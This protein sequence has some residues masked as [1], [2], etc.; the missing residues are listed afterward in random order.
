MLTK[1]PPHSADAERGVLGSILIDKDGIIQVSGL[2]SPTDFY[3]NAHTLVYDAMLDLFAVNRP[4]DL[5]TVRELL[6]DR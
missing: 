1:V 4:I 2:L 6:D 3:D 5:L